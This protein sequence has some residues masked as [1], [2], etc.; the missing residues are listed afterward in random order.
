MQILLI[1][2]FLVALL[3]SVSFL[4][5]IAAVFNKTGLVRSYD[6]IAMVLAWTLF[7]ALNLYF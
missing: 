7:Y 1:V 2:S 6:T 5:R 4:L 3:F